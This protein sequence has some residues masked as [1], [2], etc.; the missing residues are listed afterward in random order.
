M[1]DGETGG[2]R[3]GG[4]GGTTTPTTMTLAPPPR[5]ILGSSSDI[6]CPTTFVDEEGGVG[7]LNHCDV[8]KK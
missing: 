3:G 6:H 4:E 5:L 1:M 8:E 7:G 2:R